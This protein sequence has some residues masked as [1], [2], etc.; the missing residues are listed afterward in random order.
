MWVLFG[1]LAFFVDFLCDG[2][3]GQDGLVRLLSCITPEFSNLDFYCGC[4]V[5]GSL[6]C[7]SLPS[8]EFS[9]AD[10][11]FSTSFALLLGGVKDRGRVWKDPCDIFCMGSDTLQERLFRIA[12]ATF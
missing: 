12:W 9:V 8:P 3:M 6:P 1:M 2:I 5:V 7:Y 10:V 4:S 11:T